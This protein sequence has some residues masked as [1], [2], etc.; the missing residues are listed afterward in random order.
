MN[1]GE[2]NHSFY[3]ERLCFEPLSVES[4]GKFGIY[5]GGPLYRASMFLLYNINT[6]DARDSRKS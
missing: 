3:L 5:D 4:V 6:Q 2:Y 1:V